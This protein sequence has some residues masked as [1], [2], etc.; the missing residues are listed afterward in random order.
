MPLD[1]RHVRDIECRDPL[2]QRTTLGIDQLA[3]AFGRNLIAPELGRQDTDPECVPFLIR[4]PQ[5][6]DGMSR[7]LAPL[8]HRL[9]C[10]ERRQNTERAVERATVW[11]G[12]Q[13]GSDTD[14]RLVR[15]ATSQQTDQIAGRVE[16]N[17]QSRLAHPACDLSH[18]LGMRRPE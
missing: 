13:V 11:N 7:S 14:R 3:V 9:Y 1:G 18:G 8:D 4:E 6:S 15:V 5:Y 2:D 17:L 16:S 12:I 10:L